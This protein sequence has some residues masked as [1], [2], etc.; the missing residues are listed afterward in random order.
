M[1]FAFISHSRRF[2]GTVKVS[3]VTHPVTSAPTEWKRIFFKSRGHVCLGY[4]SGYVRQCCRDGWLS[5]ERPGWQGKNNSRRDSAYSLGRSTPSAR[6]ILAQSWFWSRG[7]FNLIE[8]MRHGRRAGKGHSR[9][10]RKRG[11]YIKLRLRS[12]RCSH[13]SLAKSDTCD[14][15]FFLLYCAKVNLKYI[16]CW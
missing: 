3:H 8:I 9:I 4:K 6:F 13:S 1:L 14:I 2:S 16:H 11:L 7:R 5:D 15:V 10:P 12:T